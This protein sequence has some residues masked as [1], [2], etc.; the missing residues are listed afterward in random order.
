MWYITT[1]H[2]VKAPRKIKEANEVVWGRTYSQP[3]YFIQ[4]H[5]H[6]IVKRNFADNTIDLESGHNSDLTPS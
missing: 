4:V 6:H 5:K 3:D 1:L 2:T